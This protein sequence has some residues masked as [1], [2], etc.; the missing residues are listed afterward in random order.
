MPN[1]RYSASG[2]SRAS[3]CARQ[4]ASNVAQT[5]NCPLPQT[6]PCGTRADQGDLAD[7]PIA[8]A[9]TPWQEWERNLQGRKGL[10]AGTIFEEL[11][12]PFRGTGGCCMEDRKRPCRRELLDWINVVSFA[13]DD[14]KLFLDTHPGNQEALKCFDALKRSSAQR[15]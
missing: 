1:Y 13:A 5:G 15:L 12:K 9:Y 4:A 7:L 8:M 3:G 6:P 2:I 11:D 10:P 14:T